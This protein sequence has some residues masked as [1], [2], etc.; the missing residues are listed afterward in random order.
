MNQAKKKHKV[1]EKV[2]RMDQLKAASQPSRPRGRPVTKPKGT[3]D[4]VVKR[5][6]GPSRRLAKAAPSS[7]S[8][9]KG[10]KEQ[11]SESGFLE[12]EESDS[13]EQP[14]PSESESDSDDGRV[15]Q[16]KKAAPKADAEKVPKTIKTENKKKQAKMVK[17]KP[18][19]QEKEKP[20]KLPS[21]VSATDKGSEE[22]RTVRKGKTAAEMTKTP[23]TQQKRGGDDSK[24][25]EPKKDIE[26]RNEDHE[27]PAKLR[28][29]M[30]AGEEKVEKSEAG[31][32]E[33]DGSGLVEAEM[34]KA[35]EPTKKLLGAKEP[36][37]NHEKKGA[38]SDMESLMEKPK[39]GKE[40]RV[41]FAEPPEVEIPL[42]KAKNGELAEGSQG[43]AGPTNSSQKRKSALKALEDAQPP[44]VEIPEKKAKNR[45]LAEG[46]EAAAAPTNSRQKRKSA[47]KAKEAED[48]DDMTEKRKPRKEKSSK[49]KKRSTP[50]TVL[51][52]LAERLAKRK[53]KNQSAETPHEVEEVKDMKCK[54][55]DMTA[56]SET[57]EKENQWFCVAAVSIQFPPVFLFTRSSSILIVKLKH[58]KCVKDF[59]IYTFVHANFND[60]TSN[61]YTFEPLH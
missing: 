36:K 57:H 45:E 10:K 15:L 46:S 34:S 16:S 60:F 26:K 25:E 51:P 53:A 37:P 5:A 13:S 38:K 22:P 18:S 12:S 19:T 1:D 30:K 47:L 9:A 29:R 49:D 6:R 17:V 56:Q 61:R 4:E 11:E 42:K 3:E 52:S 20:E 33:E 54:N 28:R 55:Q 50:S 39:S 7:K 27:Q 44:E 2:E 21:K 41:R 8:K 35:E 59:S 40:R 32:T 43:A 58:P 14:A 48:P 24:A 23:R 31:K